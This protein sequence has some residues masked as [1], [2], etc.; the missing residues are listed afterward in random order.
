MFL[1]RANLV[2]VYKYLG[3]MMS[4][5]GPSCASRHSFLDAWAT[6]YG[7]A[8]KTRAAFQILTLFDHPPAFSIIVVRSDTLML[9]GCHNAV[10]I[11]ALIVDAALWSLPLE[12]ERLNPRQSWEGPFGGMHSG[13][14]RRVPLTLRRTKLL[15]QTQQYNSTEIAWH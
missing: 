5:A 9:M 10:V 14:G 1:V 12:P 6:P 11:C 3:Y 7:Q 8:V 15:S 4:E 13:G 2:F